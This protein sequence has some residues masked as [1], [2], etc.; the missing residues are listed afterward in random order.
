M[1]WEGKE[2]PRYSFGLLDKEMMSFAKKVTRGAVVW[3]PRDKDGRFCLWFYKRMPRRIHRGVTQTAASDGWVRSGI[4]HLCTVSSWAVGVWNHAWPGEREGRCGD[5]MMRAQGT[6]GNIYAPEVYSSED[7]P[8]RCSAYPCPG[9]WPLLQRG[10]PR[11]LRAGRE[12]IP[13][14]VKVW[15]GPRKG[16][17]G[18][19]CLACWAQSYGVAAKACDW[20]PTVLAVPPRPSQSP[21]FALSEGTCQKLFSLSE[22]SFLPW[23]AW[24]LG[25]RLQV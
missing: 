25:R 7:W 24:Q 16:C 18:T 6:G 15:G 21:G 4:T 13:S 9:W 12:Q 22:G 19:L 20:G 2:A 11:S 23:V 1:R 10:F 8:W 3:K 17:R 5:Y 14:P